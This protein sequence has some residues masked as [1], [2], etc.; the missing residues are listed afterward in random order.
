MKGKRVAM[1]VAGLLSLCVG[2]TV[3]FPAVALHILF[4]EQVVGVSM[5]AKA[6]ILQWAIGLFC[7]GFGIWLVAQ[8]IRDKR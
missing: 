1:A 6:M 8:S 4:R 5:D 2:L 7:A 3:L